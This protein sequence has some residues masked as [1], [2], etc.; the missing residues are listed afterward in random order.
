MFY[1]QIS[2]K[3]HIFDFYQLLYVYNKQRMRA[4]C[5]MYNKV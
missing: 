1:L 3:K 4:R 5:L 2:L